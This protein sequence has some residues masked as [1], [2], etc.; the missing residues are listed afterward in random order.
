MPNA[1]AWLI[2]DQNYWDKF[3]IFGITP[4]GDVPDYLQQAGTLAGRLR[5]PTRTER[6]D[7]PGDA[8]NYH[9]PSFGQP[10]QAQR[11]RSDRQSEINLPC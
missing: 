3:G 6:A 4:G 11:C 10:G 2:F 5:R 9:L 8:L 7:V 1:T